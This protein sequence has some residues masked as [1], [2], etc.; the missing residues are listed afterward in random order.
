M[1]QPQPLQ[2]DVQ[3]RTIRA[4]DARQAMANPVVL[5][6]G[7]VQSITLTIPLLSG[8]ND[9]LVV[10]LPDEAVRGMLTHARTLPPNERTNFI[11]EWIMRNQQAVIEQHVRSGPTTRRFRYDVVPVQA[12][13]RVTEATPRRVEPA[14]QPPPT[15][16]VPRREG[17]PPA[18]VQPAAPRP[19]EQPRRVIQP[20]SPRR[21]SP[22]LTEHPVTPPAPRA[23]QHPPFPQQIRGGNGSS[24]RPYTLY[25]T[26]AEVARRGRSE[27]ILD[28]TMN[29][30]VEPVG[31]VTFRVYL[32]EA[33][34]SAA[35]RAATQGEIWQIIRRTYERV[36]SERGVR[37]DSSAFRD[38]RPGY[39]R[40][41]SRV[42]AQYDQQT[43]E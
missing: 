40:S 41:F 33:Q 11:R 24:A 37:V 36:A 25:M 38:A 17:P 10:R 16:A 13:P 14:P 6:R 23:Q 8:P 30:D 20:G 32:T 28:F 4:N 7:E 15:T 42:M 27:T 9:Y 26:P 22:P 29:F 39:N 12:Q 18:A 19:A 2:A 21:E 34:A 35:N 1:T 31:R 5:R 3:F 43:S